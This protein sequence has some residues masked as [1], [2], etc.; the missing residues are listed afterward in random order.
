M[1]LF[2]KAQDLRAH[3]QHIKS[4]NQ[5]IGFVPTMGA[6]HQGHVSLIQQSLS[7][8][9][10]TICSVFVNPTQ[11]NEASDLQKYPRTP[12]KDTELL[13]SVGTDIL[14]LPEVD[15]VY[16]SGFESQIKVNFNGLDLQME[17]AFRPGH[18]EG[19][20]QVVHRLL[21]LTEPDVIFMGQKDFQQCLIVRRMIEFLNLEV[22]L[23]VCPIIRTKEGLAMSSRNV[24]L[25]EEGKQKALVLNRA[26]AHAKV[27]LAE[28]DVS[29]VQEEV[30][31]LFEQANVKLEYFDI[32]DGHNLEPITSFK[33][34]NFIVACTAAWV[35]NVRLIDNMILKGGF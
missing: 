30:N 20:A 32:V 6:L 15:E 16:P 5:R 21:E 2:K 28:K 33:T 11:F 12:A 13:T 18:F 9:S 4:S 23:F 29:K 19:V 34:S 17:G 14:F 10:H 1:Y 35:E 8:C 27:T 31:V 25:S 24:L 7:V 22:E 3:I 26:L